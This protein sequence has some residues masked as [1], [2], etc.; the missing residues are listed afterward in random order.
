MKTCK[1][2]SETRCSPY[3]GPMMKD[4]QL[5]DKGRCIYKKKKK[6]KSAVK[7]KTRNNR[8]NY[9]ADA[10]GRPQCVPI[11]ACDYEARTHIPRLSRE[12]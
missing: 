1:K 2:I 10:T 5:S 12:I 9:R 6:K 7:K 3:D 4:C 8:V 11:K